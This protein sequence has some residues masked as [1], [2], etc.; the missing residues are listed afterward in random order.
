MRGNNSFLLK[1]AINL[2]FLYSIINCLLVW[3]GHT[4]S[5]T[6]SIIIELTLILLLIFILT[7]KINKSIL[8]GKR[9]FITYLLWCF[10]ILFESLSNLVGKQNIAFFTHNTLSTLSISL[11]FIFSEISNIKSFYQKYIKIG[12]PIFLILSPLMMPGCWGWYLTPIH[13]IIIFLPKI[14]IKWKIIYCIL[15]VMSIYDIGTRANLLRGI[16]ALGCLF[17]LQIKKTSIINFLSKALSIMLLIG[18]IILLYLGITGTYNI[19]ESGQNQK[20]QFYA[21]TRTLLYEEVIT[22]SINNNYI[23]TGRTFAHGYDS[24]FQEQFSNSVKKA[25]RTSEVSACNIFT[26]AGGIGLGL[27]FLCFI[28]SIYYSVFKSHNTYIKIIGVYLA[29]R[30][31][32]AFIEENNNID[33]MNIT[34]FIVM[35]LCLN[36]YLINQGNKT[37][38][39]TIKKLTRS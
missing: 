14:N 35:G 13:I 4:Y 17:L 34:I 26:W 33:P 22:S 11:I 21:D 20:D 12:I 29:F 27:H 15:F 25:E 30:W 6:F 24:K 1:I 39:I 37:F 23:W 36:P 19:F 32:M 28:T 38:L 10:F 3:S 18:P 5:L 7:K 16:A 9:I 31:F 8:L 2:F